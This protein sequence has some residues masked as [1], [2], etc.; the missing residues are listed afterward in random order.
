MAHNLFLELS[1][2]TLGKSNHLRSSDFTN[3]EFDEISV[4]CLSSQQELLEA[5]VI[6]YAGTM[7]FNSSSSYRFKFSSTSDLSIKIS[8]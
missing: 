1:G 5:S 7:Y 6:E 2:I 8:M 4:T 3:A